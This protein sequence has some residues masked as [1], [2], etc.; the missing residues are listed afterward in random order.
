MRTTWAEEGLR[1]WVVAAHGV[2]CVGL[3]V[4]ILWLK[5]PYSTVVFLAGPVLLASAHF[6]RRVYLAMTPPAA[7]AGLLAVLLRA[8][9][10]QEALVALLGLALTVAATSEVLFRLGL[11]HRATQEQ[12]RQRAAVL[13]ALHATTVGLLQG[14]PAQDLLESLLRRACQFLGTPH[15]N[16]FLVEGDRIRCRFALGATRWM[17]EEGLEVPPGR[18]L[19][20][21]VWQTGKPLVVNDYARWEGRIPDPRL[22]FVRYAAAMPVLV[23]GKVTGVIV[24]VRSETDGPFSEEET[25]AVERFAELASLVVQ[26][27]ELYRAAREELARRQR[28]EAD[29]VRQHELLRA[30][31]ATAEELLSGTEFDALLAAVVHRACG[32]LRSNHGNLYLREG[33]VMRCRVGV[34]AARW[35]EEA[36]LCLHRGEGMVGRVWEAG[37]LLVVED[38]A[39]WPGR[40]S[41]PQ[42]DDLGPALTVP[43]RL[44]QEVM[45][46]FFV[47]RN[48]GEP[49]F[50][51]EEVDAARRFGHLASL[52]LHQASLYRAAREELDRRTQ[53]ERALRRRQELLEALQT[54]SVALLEGAQL[55]RTLDS[56]VRKACE[57]LSCPHV[58]LYLRE[59]ELLRCVVG[60]GALTQDAVRGRTVQKGQGI[61]GTVWERLAPVAVEDYATWPGRQRQSGTALDGLGPGLA[62]PLWRGPEYAG[63]L[64]LARDR[65]AAVFSPDED[66]VAHRFAQAA[67]LVLHNAR[68]YREAQEEVA[69]R[70]EVEVRLRRRQK[71]LEALHATTQGLLAG[72]GAGELLRAIVQRAC[73]LLGS[74]HGNL[75]LLEDGV[76]RCRA[77]LGAMAWAGQEGL[78]VRPGEGM[79]GRVWETGEPVVVENYSQWPGRLRDPR[80]DSIG[81]A[82]SVPLLTGGQFVGAFSV[83]RDLTAPAF[84]AEEIETVVRFGQLAS[85]VLQNTRLVEQAQAAARSLEEQRAFYEG[86]LNQVESEIAVFDPELRYVYVNPAAVRDPEL[87]RWIIGRDDY[88]CCLRKGRDPSLAARRQESLRRAIQER[89]VVEHEET[90]VTPTGEQRYYV[91]RACPVLDEVGRV[92]RVIGYGLDITDRKRAELRLAHLALH[93]ALTGLPN[94]TLFLDRLQHALNR[95]SRTSKR[96]AVLFVDLD[97]FKAVNDALG[98]EAG[99]SLLQQVAER[100]RSCVRSSDTLARL[101]GDEF[102]VLLEDVA[103]IHEAQAVAERIRAALQ[104]PFPVAGQHL[105]TTASVGVALSGPDTRQAADLLR[106]SDAAM[107]RAKSSGRNRVC[108]HEPPA[109]SALPAASGTEEGAGAPPGTRSPAAGTSEPSRSGSG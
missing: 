15:G 42:V 19:S 85:L 89:R 8:P 70:R 64:F 26:N 58:A 101:A 47:A 63:T 92:V 76:L 52:V 33:D 57:L 60:V 49:P 93:D 62:V 94:R 104:Q 24:V 79:V 28:A 66:D 82:V 77:G 10:L 31:Y 86:I 14:G 107:Y 20:G 45:G 7:A 90:V 83:A 16:L 40:L 41:F 109:D 35:A 61:V 100:L 78:V 23:H 51:D 69:R 1:L 108:L 37:H 56:V 39:G 106:Q 43:L 2:L 25:R 18:G 105:T 73:E 95:A 48:R 27:E 88:A 55:E 21:H 67:A 102:T 68:L 3:V 59:G 54:T 98:H 5:I 13:D 91:R 53:L 9:D 75:Y 46:A 11:S 30:L 72:A 29:L 50:T 84:T 12:L 44:G 34:G 65:G 97:R 32:L 80:F 22:A 74:S 71:L 36:G 99:D 103:D 96:V 87:R 17:E 81:G 4:A 6:P 38:Y